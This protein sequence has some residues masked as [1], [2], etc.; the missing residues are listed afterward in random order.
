[1][2]F[3]AQARAAT[4]PRFFRS[5]R[6]PLVFEFD[7]PDVGSSRSTL[8]SDAAVSRSE[9]RSHTGFDEAVVALGVPPE[10]ARLVPNDDSLAATIVAL[11]SSARLV[12]ADWYRGQV[13]GYRDAGADP[14]A[15]FTTKGWK[16]GYSPNYYFD[17][18]FYLAQLPAG[19]AASINPLLHYLYVGESAGLRP[20]PHL[21]PA[22]YRSR[23]GLIGQ[24][25]LCHYLANLATTDLR[26][27]RRVRHRLLSA[28]QRGRPEGRRRS[29]S[30]LRVLR[31]QRGPP[32]A[33]SAGRRCERVGFAPRGACGGQGREL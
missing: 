13:E 24:S 4:L 21:D 27:E 12:D 19:A 30:P 33:R 28:G 26:A 23:Y 7:H 32:A 14:V 9:R 6:A 22:W 31:A 18:S 16:L 15:H 5:D 20:S 10:M 25:A 2:R 17:P 11:L 1:M 29:V 8:G 3:F